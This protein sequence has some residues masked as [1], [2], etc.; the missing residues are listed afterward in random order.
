VGAGPCRLAAPAPTVAD[1]TRAN[2]WR[3]RQ[4]RLRRLL[5]AALHAGARPRPWHPPPDR[6][7]DIRRQQ[8]AGA[9]KAAMVSSWHP[10]RYIRRAGYLMCGEPASSDYA[11]PRA[12]PLSARAG[13]ARVIASG[14]GGATMQTMQPSVTLGLLHLGRRIR[15]PV[16]EFG[17][18]ALRELC[19]PA[20]VAQRRAGRRCWFTADVARADAAL[21]YAQQLS[22]RRV[23]WGMALLPRAGEPRALAAMSTRDLPAM[24]M[25]DAGSPTYKSGMGPGIGRRTY[26]PMDRKL[27]STARQPSRS[28]RLASIRCA[29]V[30]VASRRSAASAAISC[31]Q[32]A[33]DIFCRCPP[34]RSKPAA[35][36]DE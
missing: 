23:R 21:A 15:L 20:R 35:R 30:L 22:F 34:Q 19:A 27:P 33:D 11:E 4:G 17:L 3:H 31:L 28:A 29:P 5:P 26:R 13:A 16:D 24:R 2:Q 25:A 12:R 7:G 6:P 18:G 36:T 8:R 1:V 14:V 32:R 9:G 10:T